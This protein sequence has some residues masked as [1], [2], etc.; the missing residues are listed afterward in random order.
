MKIYVTGDGLIKNCKFTEP[1][2]LIATHPKQ[3]TIT[4]EGCTFLEHNR[5]ETI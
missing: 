1:I 2:E 4:I 5:S 3:D